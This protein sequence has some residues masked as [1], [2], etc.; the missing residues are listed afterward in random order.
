MWRVDKPETIGNYIII[1][2][3]IIG[4]IQ[5]PF[6]QRVTGSLTR[7]WFDGERFSLMQRGFMHNYPSSCEVGQCVWTPDPIIAFN[8]FDSNGPILEVEK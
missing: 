7:A 6:P 3:E 2:P 4:P 8:G 1:I 5:D